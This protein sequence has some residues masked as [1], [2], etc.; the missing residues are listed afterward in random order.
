MHPAYRSE[1]PGKA[2]DCGMDLVPVYEERGSRDAIE[3]SPDRQQK[4]GVATA[5]AERRRLGGTIRTSGRVVADETRLARVTTK[6]DGTIERLYADFT[7]KTVRR[8]QPLFTVYSPDLLA[9]QE[10][11]L[12]AIRAGAQLPGLAEAA[13]QRLRLWDVTDGELRQLERSGAPKRSVTIVSPASGIV[14]AKTAVAGA[15][16]MAGQPL[17]DIADLS[18]VWVLA[19]IYESEL[20]SIRAGSRA[21]VTI[22]SLPGRTFLGQVTFIAPL[23]DEMTRTVK[24]RIEIEN[25]TGELK[26]DMYADVS[27]ES[28]PHDAVVVPD[29]AVLQTGTRSIVFIASDG[30]FEPRE[31]QTGRKAEG[32]FE[33]VHGLAGGE[34]VVTQANFLIDSESRLRRVEQGAK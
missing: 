4:I 19:D 10:E 26:P 18:H 24:V 12:L 11:Y 9:A 29:D 33:I 31:V 21:D 25:R 23:V 32:L 14:T 8:G 13:R 1:K 5:V 27:I 2:P 17:F 34:R 30:R 6:F 7:G 28:P 16:V 22:A 15:R 20:P 3:I